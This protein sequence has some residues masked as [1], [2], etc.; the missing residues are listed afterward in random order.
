MN[1]SNSSASS[2]QSNLLSLVN[3]FFS[4]NDSIELT[5]FIIMSLSD[6]V[7][8]EDEKGILIYSQ[9]HISEVSSELNSLSTFIL[10]L[11]RLN[12]EV[13]HA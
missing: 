12:K 9:S 8:K 11:E 2:T 4:E 7:S 13:C 6:H 3:D 10:K 1:I 5:R